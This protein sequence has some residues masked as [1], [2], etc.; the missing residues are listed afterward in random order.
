M[1]AGGADQTLQDG[2]SSGRPEQ[3]VD[4][5]LGV[6]HQAEHVARTVGHPG[7]AGE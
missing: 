5:V 1:V 4:R 2:H 3:W 6:R 7:D